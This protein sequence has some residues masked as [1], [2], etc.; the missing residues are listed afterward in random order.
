MKRK[1]NFNEE[2]ESSNGEE[3]NFNEEEES[4]NGEEKPA[5]NGKFERQLCQL[6]STHSPGSCCAPPGYFQNT[7]LSFCGKR[8][9]TS[10][11]CTLLLFSDTK[12][13]P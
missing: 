2:E 8:K 4:S 7:F 6:E 13:I 1:K 11:C 3:E 9:E 5:D 10:S 12:P